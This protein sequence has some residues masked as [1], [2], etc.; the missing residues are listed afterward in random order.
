M[1]NENVN[2]QLKVSL[3]WNK[4]GTNKTI[5]AELQDRLLFHTDENLQKDW[6][7]IL[8]YDFNPNDEGSDNAV[9]RLFNNMVKTPEFQI[10]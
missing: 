2:Q 9:M 6:E 1:M 4:S 8:K 5:I 3:N 7:T 10:I